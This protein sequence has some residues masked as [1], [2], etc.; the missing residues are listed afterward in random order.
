M[1]YIFKTNIK[2][3]LT[4]WFFILLLSNLG[5]AKEFEI[6]EELN[7]V[8]Y[9]SNQARRKSKIL[10][11]EIIQLEKKIKQIKIDSEHLS[12][13]V[14]QNREYAGKRLKALYKMSMSLGFE[15]P[16]QPMS[17]FDFSVLQKSM[18]QIIISDLHLIEKQNSDLEKLAALKQKVQKE[19]L[20]KTTLEIEH[21]DQIAVNKKKSLK[22]K[23]ILKKIRKQKNLAL[24]AGKSLK[25]A[26][27]QLDT[28]LNNIQKTQKSSLKASSFPSH[29]GKLQIPVN[30]KIISKYGPLKTGDYKLA[31]FQKG[32]DIK[33]DRGE[34]VKSVFKGEIMFAQW[35]KG[36]GNVLIIDH[37]NNY[38]TLYAHVEEIFKQKGAIVDT[39]E[40]IATAG[41]TGSI[42]GTCLHF[43]VRHHGKPV[44]PM[45]WLKKAV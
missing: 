18:K 37:G 44:N 4:A 21:S 1:L 30:G 17:I 25:K 27:V 36:Y 11:A 38:Y 35:L 16:D 43:E 39:G 26:A 41:D 9:A 5:F 2:I 24:A 20:A 32:I 14:L 12:D 8:D 23:L 6:I 42:K 19:I 28:Q 45:K 40:V 29:K 22:K 15:M 13:E 34:P 31:A 3:A 10:S 7:K 33:V